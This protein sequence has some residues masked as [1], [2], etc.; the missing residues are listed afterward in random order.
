[1]AKEMVA[2]L[3]PNASSSGTMKTLGEERVPAA[4]S[5]LRKTTA[6]TT[7]PKWKRVLTSRAN[8]YIGR[9]PQGSLPG[10]PGRLR[11]L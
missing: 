8:A 7:H 1:M 6:A 10:Q 4:T 2:R 5:R 9:S 3:Q 11:L